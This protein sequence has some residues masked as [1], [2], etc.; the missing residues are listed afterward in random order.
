V[1][2]LVF[3]KD[4]NSGVGPVDVKPVAEVKG[5]VRAPRPSEQAAPVSEAHST[6]GFNAVQGPSRPACS[7]HSCVSSLDVEKE[8]GTALTAQP[9]AMGMSLGQAIP[10]PYALPI[11]PSK[12]QG[13]QDSARGA[14]GVDPGFGR[15]STPDHQFEVR[16]RLSSATQAD[17]TSG[18]PSKAEGLI[19]AA[20]FTGRVDGSYPGLAS[21]TSA[22]GQAQGAAQYQEN[23]SKHARHA[24]FQEKDASGSGDGCG[25]APSPGQ[26]F[27]RI[28]GGV[29][30]VSSVYSQG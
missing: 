3:A 17:Q 27:S 21:N 18:Q 14:A 24:Q 11:A 23:A 29:I 9:L 26:G 6:G 5:D 30:N 2:A 16:P 13:D 25:A 8:S 12:V 15:A 10:L 20:T 1:N 19:S 7:I 28:Q 4:L 22:S